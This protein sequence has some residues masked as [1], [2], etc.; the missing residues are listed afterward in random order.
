MLLVLF[1]FESRVVSLRHCI[2]EEQ[3]LDT[4]VRM[5]KYLEGL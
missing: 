3:R 5:A 4:C 1:V 2:P